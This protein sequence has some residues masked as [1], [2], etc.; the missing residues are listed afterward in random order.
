MPEESPKEVHPA[1]FQQRFLAIRESLQAFVLSKTL[2]SIIASTR[3]PRVEVIGAENLKQIEG[4]AIFAPNHSGISIFNFELP[5]MDVFLLMRLINEFTRKKPSVI[6]KVN[7]QIPP[8]PDQRVQAVLQ[9]LYSQI[10]Q[11]IPVDTNAQ[12][13]LN[14]MREALQTLLGGSPILIFPGETVQFNTI[15]L[16]TPLFNGAAYLA[17]KANAPLIPTLILNATSIREVMSGVTVIFG[18]PIYPQ[19]DISGLKGFDKRTMIR[20]L[21]QRMQ[22]EMKNLYEQHA[23]KS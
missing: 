11:V 3:I 1:S 6:G 17:L 7:L 12:F 9:A 16:E 8:V 21:T 22:V 15:D 13:P 20:D 18:T 14:T 2:E 23:Q 5:A 19:G 4:A 10:S